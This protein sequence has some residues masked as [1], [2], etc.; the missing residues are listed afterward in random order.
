MLT[1]LSKPQLSEQMR[2]WIPPLLSGMIALLL[3]TLLGHAP[4]LRAG[5]M[6]IAVIGVTASLRALGQLV[7]IVGGLTFA[8]SPASWAQA[9]GNLSIDSLSV[10]YVLVFAFGVAIII[11]LFI[12]NR[13]LYYAAIIGVTLT[14]VLVVILNESVRSTR[15]SNLLGAWLIYMLMIALRK[16]NPR[17][18]DPPAKEISQRHQYAVL[19]LYLL[20]VF[21]DPLFSL[22]APALLIGLWLSRIHLPFWQWVVYGVMTFYGGVLFYRVYISNEWSF[23]LAQLLLDGSIA[24]PYLILSGWRNTDRWIMLMREVANQYTVV[25]AIISLFG[26]ARFSRWHPPLSTMLLFGYGSFFVFG[27]MYFGPNETTYMIPLLGIQI[28][29]LTYGVHSIGQWILRYTQQTNSTI[30][31]FLTAL[32]LILPIVQLGRIITER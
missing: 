3:F 6:S 4:L 2:Y 8:L 7:C 32:F 19:V 18:E 27:L 25:G 9:S 26:I 28:I 17:P 21:N 10:G 31:R 22:Y 30:P 12:S 29:W 11:F 16:T 24:P 15:I 13:A 20:G 1:S 5:A 14:V 23:H